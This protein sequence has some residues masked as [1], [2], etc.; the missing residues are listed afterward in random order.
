MLKTEIR[1][2]GEE[3]KPVPPGLKIFLTCNFILTCR[4]FSEGEH[5]TSRINMK[6][7]TT[8]LY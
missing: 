2:E 5:L 7:E 1:M 6:F 4:Q 3:D 8:D